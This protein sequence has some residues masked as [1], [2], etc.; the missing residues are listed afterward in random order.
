M[1]GLVMAATGKTTPGV[2]TQAMHFVNQDANETDYGYL[3][4]YQFAVK[5]GDYIGTGSG[6]HVHDMA[7][8][9]GVGSLIEIRYLPV[10]PFL[11]EPTTVSRIPGLITSA[12]SLVLIGLSLHLCFRRVRESPEGD[13]TSL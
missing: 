8:V 5:G 2:V 9:P 12:F 3:I 13:L 4:R 11:N 1:Y 10:A 6:Q 7:R